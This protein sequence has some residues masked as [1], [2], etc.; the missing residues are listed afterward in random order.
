M[1]G[2]VF[3]SI[4]VLLCS[5]NQSVL[6]KTYD[7]ASFVKDS[8]A[9]KEKL[10]ERTFNDLK[11]YINDFKDTSIS[12]FTYQQL[13]NEAN[14]YA[15]EQSLKKVDEKIAVR[16]KMICAKEWYIKSISTSGSGETQD[17]EYVDIPE[18]N[19]NFEKPYKKISFKEDDTFE[20]IRKD[21]PEVEKGKWDVSLANFSFDGSH[22]KIDSISEKR[23]VITSNERS[24]FGAFETNIKQTITFLALEGN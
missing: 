18:D 6:E 11:I 2:I 20:Q 8:I 17:N 7:A 13:I 1:R 10:S 9:L 24:S 3:L 14:L 19:L 5:C 12:K 16:K 21:D 15:Q 23:I 22:Y 4:L